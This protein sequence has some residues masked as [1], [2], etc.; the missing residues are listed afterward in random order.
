[1]GVEACERGGLE[2]TEAD[3]T[4]DDVRDDVVT[5]EEDIEDDVTELDETDDADD[6]EEEL[7]EL[8]LC[9]KATGVRERAMEPAVIK[10]MSLFIS[11]G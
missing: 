9:A 6:T 4:D 3:D 10:A 5:E 8:A 11:K 7:R 2:Y 1:M